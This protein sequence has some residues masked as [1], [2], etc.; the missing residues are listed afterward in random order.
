MSLQF[1][2][3]PHI[4]RLNKI[5]NFKI[6]SVAPSATFLFPDSLGSASIIAS[7]FATPVILWTLFKLKRYGWLIGFC[8]F[9]II[10]YI[11]INILVEEGTWYILYL[12]P[13]LFLFVYYFI[14]KQAIKDW[15]EP[16]FVNKPGSDYEIHLKNKKGR[17]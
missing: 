16:I 9:V 4:D 1:K 11:A 17:K 12:F 8:V 15:R 6:D 5:L 10:P 14:L 3:N 13:M 2:H 7:V